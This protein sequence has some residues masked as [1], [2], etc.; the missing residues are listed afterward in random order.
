[1]LAKE[2][3]NRHFNLLQAEGEYECS[4]MLNE[5]RPDYA[6]VDGALGTDVC[7][8]IVDHLKADSRVPF[9]RI[10]VL[11]QLEDIAPECQTG[12]YAWVN[13]P[14]T[15]EDILDCLHLTAQDDVDGLKA[16]VGVQA[17][18]GK[19]DLTRAK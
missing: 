4:A 10:V 6:V 14:C 3:R 5:F 15:T 11:G 7:S 19:A 13:K 9:L 12:I 8:R 2:A 1:M 17:R 18:L 16:G